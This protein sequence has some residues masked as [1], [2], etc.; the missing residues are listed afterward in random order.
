MAHDES[1]LTVSQKAFKL[2]FA[3]FL[4]HY[5]KP[6]VFVG[7]GYGQATERGGNQTEYSES[8][9]AA[10]GC[11]TVKIPLWERRNGTATAQTA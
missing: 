1:N 4:P 7:P 5:L 8:E 10:T 9:L 11:Q 6:L 2:G 3:Y